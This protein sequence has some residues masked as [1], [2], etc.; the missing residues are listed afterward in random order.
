MLDKGR[1]VTCSSSLLVSPPVF[2]WD[3]LPIAGRGG[4]GSECYQ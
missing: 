2:S 4:V 3:Q 1:G